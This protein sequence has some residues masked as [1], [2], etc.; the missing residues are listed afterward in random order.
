MGVGKCEGAVVPGVEGVFKPGP[1]IA[2][3]HVSWRFVHEALD[4]G[5]NPAVVKD[6]GDRDWEVT[7]GCPPTLAYKFTLS[8]CQD[9]AN[10]TS[11]EFTEVVES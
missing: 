6:H 10:T 9:E 11:S 3:L 1:Q 8:P 4:N 2:Q 5:I 7:F